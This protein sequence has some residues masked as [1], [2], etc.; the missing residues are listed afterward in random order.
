MQEL[1]RTND[2]VLLSFATSLMKDAGI[3]CMVAD[4]SISVLEGSIPM[5]QK[6]FLVT[7]DDADEARALLID[8]GLEAE[9]RDR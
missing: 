9:L 5:I 4:E 6:R 7:P 3:H 2:V 8:A 1:I